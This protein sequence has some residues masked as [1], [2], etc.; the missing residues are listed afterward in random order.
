MWV[1]DVQF[2]RNNLEYYLNH[3]KKDYEGNGNTSYNSTNREFLNKYVNDLYMYNYHIL[4]PNENKEN[5]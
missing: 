3:E 4:H 2:N 5:R 1:D